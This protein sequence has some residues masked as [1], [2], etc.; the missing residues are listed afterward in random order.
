MRG[1][2]PVL[3]VFR[4][5]DQP[6][7]WEDAGFECMWFVQGALHRAIFKPEMLEPVPDDPGTSGL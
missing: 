5:V 2:G 4:V 3:N 6:A 7:E 1:G